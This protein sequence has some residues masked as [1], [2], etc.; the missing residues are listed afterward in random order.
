M[1][2]IAGISDHMALFRI[3]KQMSVLLYV[4]GMSE[5]VNK[6]TVVLVLGYVTRR[7]NGEDGEIR[8]KKGW[9]TNNR[10]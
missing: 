6:K 9:R 1:I 2:N 3:L 10:Q 5:N 4:E 8:R 7:Q